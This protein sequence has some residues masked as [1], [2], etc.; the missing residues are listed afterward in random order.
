M[1]D[2]IHIMRNSD[3]LISTSVLYTIW[4]HESQS[5]S[6][7]LLPFVKV[8]L[9]KIQSGIINVPD[10][11]SDMRNEFGLD[12]PF[13]VCERL[14]KKISRGE[15]D[16]IIKRN[17]EFVLLTSDIDVSKLMEEIRQAKGSIECVLGELKSYLEANSKHF[18]KEMDIVQEFSFFLERYGYYYFRDAKSAI[19][20]TQR[21]DSINYSIGKFIIEEYEKQSFTFERITQILNGLMI[22]KVLMYEAEN[23]EISAARYRKVTFYLD[24]PILLH[25]LGFLS[26]YE[27]QSTNQM[28]ELLATMGASFACFREHYQ[29]V[30]DILTAYIKNKQDRRYTRRTLA[31]LDDKNLSIPELIVLR[32]TLDSKLQAQGIE[33]VERPEYISNS[34]NGNSK[35]KYIDENALSNAIKND[36]PG[37]SEKKNNALQ[38][39][40]LAISAISL[41]RNGRVSNKLENCAAVFV[42]SNTPLVAC[43]CKYFEK[44]TPIMSIPL[45][46]DNVYLTTHAWLKSSKKKINLSL[47]NIIA[48]ATAAIRPSDS[49]R[50]AAIKKIDDMEANG[51]FTTDEATIAKINWM[52][53]EF[54][55]SSEGDADCLTE[56]DITEALNRYKQ[57]VIDKEVQKISEV[58]IAQEANRLSDQKA[59]EEAI[60]IIQQIRDYAKKYSLVFERALTAFMKIIGFAII[61]TN[62]SLTILGISDINAISVAATVFALIQ[63]ID[64]YIT[65][66]SIVKGIIRKWKNRIEEHIFDNKLRTAAMYNSIIKRIEDE[67]ALNTI[68]NNVNM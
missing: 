57:T 48:N 44:D 24:T 43:V 30:V 41:L 49:F 16:T 26:E 64:F 2:R 62:I 56:S 45:I 52:L 21:A 20:Y 67:K 27:R 3:A 29:E 35:H 42:T 23:N 39:D 13:R 66:A 34:T 31:G 37:Y 36:I 4:V 33:V 59:S 8:G 6:D 50:A 46:L 55:N 38:N 32:E 25:L 9:S 68:D 63:V 65:K 60:R 40:V 54:Y 11:C 19:V 7:I 10:L 1:N 22:A 14:L 17:Q 12:I 51:S 58:S 53:D 47:L 61:L 18:T 15:P 5:F 28:I